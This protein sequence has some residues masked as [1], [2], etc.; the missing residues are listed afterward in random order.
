MK[1]LADISGTQLPQLHQGSVLLD[2]RHQIQGQWQIAQL[3]SCIDARAHGH[4]VH[5][6]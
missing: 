1:S 2:V 4:L 5:N 3:G 6:V